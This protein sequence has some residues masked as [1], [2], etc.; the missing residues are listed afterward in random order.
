MRKF[1]TQ[2]FNDFKKVKEVK[3]ASSEASEAI[4][5]PKP[6]LKFEPIDVVGANQVI[7]GKFNYHSTTWK[8][9]QHYLDSRI[10]YL[11][12]QNENKKRTIE[13]TNYFRGQIKEI[14]L[15]LKHTNQLAG[16]SNSPIETSLG[17]SPTDKGLTYE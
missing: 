7:S 2:W 16:I 4:A 9:L 17:S 15:L 8:Y 10:N 13:E 6:I 11:H 14:R 12:N 3:E 5:A 1:F